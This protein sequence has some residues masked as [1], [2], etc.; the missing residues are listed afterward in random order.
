MAGESKTEQLMLILYSHSVSYILYILYLNCDGSY[1]SVLV[2]IQN[3]TLENDDCTVSTLSLN[4]LLFKNKTK[5]TYLLGL[6]FSRVNK[7][8]W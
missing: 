1:I 5:H 8:K 4:K 7:Q 6:P 3:C 2:K